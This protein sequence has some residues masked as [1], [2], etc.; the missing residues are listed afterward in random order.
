MVFVI[1]ALLHE[2]VTA[3]IAVVMGL[4]A[5]VLLIYVFWED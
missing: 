1:V 5:F 4:L 2:G 3:S